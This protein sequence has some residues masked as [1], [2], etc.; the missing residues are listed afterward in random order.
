MYYDAKGSHLAS[1]GLKLEIFLRCHYLAPLRHGVQVIPDF[2]WVDFLFT[3]EKYAWRIL[4]FLVAR[5]TTE[6]GI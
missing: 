6:K 2:S 3:A 1:S 5:E 4:V